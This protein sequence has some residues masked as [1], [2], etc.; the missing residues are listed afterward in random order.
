MVA[1]LL[2]L[3]CVA[4]A[5]AATLI[6]SITVVSSSLNPS[7]EGN[8]LTFTSTTTANGL[9]ITTGAIDWS[10]RPLPGGS[11]TPAGSPLLDANGQTTFTTSALT[12]GNTLVRAAYAGSSEYTPSDST[13]VQT[14]NAPPPPSKVTLTILLSS[15]TPSIF[16]DLVTFTS[17]TFF[18]GLAPTGDVTF[19]ARLNNAPVETFV[20]SIDATGFAYF[21][22]STL[23]VGN[24]F[25]TAAY[26]GDELHFRSD[27]SLLQ[28]V[29][30]PVPEPATWALMLAGLA[31]L[32]G[33]R[34]RA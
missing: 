12:L 4:P 25:V 17:Q 15:L 16:G 11:V 31:L 2:M 13:L 21:S 30:A 3:G 1:G 10:Y 27:G 6:P 24:V 7:L 28:Q 23:P 33:I 14:V 29:L 5:A 9:P 20:T 32:A 8:S 26:A 18:E 34:R 19:T 22:T